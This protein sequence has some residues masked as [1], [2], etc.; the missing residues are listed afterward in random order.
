MPNYIDF[1]VSCPMDKSRT[2]SIR[3]YYVQVD[4]S[5]LPLPPNICDNGCGSDICSRCIA[6]L[7]DRALQQ[8]PPF[9][10]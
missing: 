7:I 9:P 6:D 5:W 10:G 4:G 3:V 8:S 2:E 1:T